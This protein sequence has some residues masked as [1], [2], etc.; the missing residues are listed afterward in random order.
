M[1]NLI[2]FPNLKLEHLKSYNKLGIFVAFG[3]RT[4]ILLN[5]NLDVL[6]KYLDSN[7]SEKF[8]CADFFECKFENFCSPNVFF[9]LLGGESG[10]IKII[11]LKEGKLVTFLKG[12]TGAICDMKVVD[13]YVVS[14][15]EDSSIRI[16]DLKTLKCVSMCGGL[17]GHKDHVLSLDVLHDSSMIVSVGTDCVIKQWEFKVGADL[18]FNHEPFSSFSNV[19]KC[20]ITK[21]KYCGNLILSLS[22][23][24]VSV[25]YNHANREYFKENFNLDKNDPVYIGTVELFGNCKSFEIYGHMLIGVSTNADVYIFDLRNIIKEKTPYL[26]SMNFN[27]AEDII[28]INDTFYITSGN[29]IHSFDIDLGHF[30]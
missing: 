25:I 18:V 16:W 10:T 4:A 27:S 8:K 30:S 13:H 1:A 9:L 2:E 12:H 21:V 26:L 14:C 11:D 7:K 15:S 24:I 22:N 20:Q 29:A 3:F 17:A 5:S 23:N 6:C 28:H 19:H